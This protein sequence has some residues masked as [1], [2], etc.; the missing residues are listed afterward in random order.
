MASLSQWVA[1]ARPRTLPAAVAP[2]VLGTAAAHLVG[3]ADVALGILALVVAL[4]AAGRGELRQRLLRR[5]PRHRRGPGRPGAPGRPAARRPRQRQARGD[6]LVRRGRRRRARPGGAVRGV[7]HAAARRAGRARRV[8]LHRWRQP[9]RL[10]RPRRG[11]RLR[12]LRP[13]GHARHAVHPGGCRDLV[14]RARRRR[15]G[16]GRLGDP[17]R[18]QPAR[19]PDRH[20]ARQAHPRRAPGRPAH[21]AALHRRWSRSRC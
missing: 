18:E 17:G 19:H 2:V 21:P 3:R 11:L 20:R 10:P 16:C 6:A 15:R 7:D 13:D 5:H 8:A 1:G 14:R 9:L 12:L 4:V